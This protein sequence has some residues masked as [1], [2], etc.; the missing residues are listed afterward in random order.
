MEY[1][2]IAKNYPSD[3]TQEVNRLIEEGWT[4]QGGISVSTELDHN[5]FATTTTIYTFVQAMVRIKL[6]LN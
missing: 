1:I 2:I 6:N 3:V 4:C 5:G